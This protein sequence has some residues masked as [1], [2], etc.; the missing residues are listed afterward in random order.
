MA[1]APDQD[2]GSPWLPDG[3]TATP[4]YSWTLSHFDVM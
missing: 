3:H 1:W 4:E 2:T